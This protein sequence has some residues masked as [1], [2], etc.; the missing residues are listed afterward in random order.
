MCLILYHYTINNVIATWYNIYNTWCLDIRIS[1][2][3]LEFDHAAVANKLRK[4]LD[5]LSTPSYDNMERSL[6]ANKV[7]TANE[8]KIIQDKSGGD[9]MEYLIVEIILPSLMQEF[10]KKYKAFFE[11]MEENEDTALQNAAKNLGMDI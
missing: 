6:F 4:Q 11:V 10:C 3:F 1:T 7:I 5:K 2:C 8:R 9:K